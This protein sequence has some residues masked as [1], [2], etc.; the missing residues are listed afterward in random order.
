LFEEDKIVA[1]GRYF[2]ADE[3]PNCAVFEGPN[4]QDAVPDWDPDLG[5]GL[6]ISGLLSLGREDSRN[7]YGQ[8]KKRYA[9]G[10]KQSERSTKPHWHS[11]RKIS[12]SI[13][14][15]DAAITRVAV[16]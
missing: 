8:E 15:I 2:L 1:C 6:G 13:A 14:A 3:Y 9:R 7:G 10:L 16:R 12:K 5:S 11:E 4:R